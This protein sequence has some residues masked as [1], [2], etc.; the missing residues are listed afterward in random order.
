MGAI[1]RFVFGPV[2]TKTL[3]NGSG[4]CLHGTHD[5]AGL[6]NTTG[7]PGVSIM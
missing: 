5:E 4:P 1:P 6:R 7:W 2:I 3:K